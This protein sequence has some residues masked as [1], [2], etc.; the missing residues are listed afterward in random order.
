GNVDGALSQKIEHIRSQL[1]GANRRLI[2]YRR[3]ANELERETIQLQ[4]TKEAIE[5]FQKGYEYLVSEMNISVNNVV[6]RELLNRREA[7]LDAYTSARER[8]RQME[9]AIA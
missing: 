1:D 7:K 5:R 4:Q 2:E 6:V 9:G 3:Q 8:F